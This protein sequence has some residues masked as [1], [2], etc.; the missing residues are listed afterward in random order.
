MTEITIGIDVSKKRLDV[1]V[2]PSGDEFTT[3]NDE[4]SCCELAAKLKSLNPTLIVL[5]ATGGLENLVTGVLVAEG[6]PAVVINPRQARD[7]AKATGRLAKTDR[8][9]AKVLALFGV[10]IKPEP[11]PYKDEDA[12]A[13]TAL[14][15]RRRQI[16]DMITAER[17][18]LASSHSSVKNDIAQ[19]IKWLE[20]RVKDIDDDLSGFIRR[21]ALWKA[22]ADILT[23]CKGIGPVVSTT[24]LCSLPELGTLNRRQISGL[25]GVCPY[26]RDSGTMRGKR[27][28]FGGRATVRAMLYMAALSA[29]RFNPVIKTFYDR[30]IRAGKA[31]K[32]A[33]VACMRKLLTILN[34]MLKDMKPWSPEF[35][36]AP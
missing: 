19:T 32:V 17:N 26:N 8:I 24:M 25:V 16:I 14:I 5:E 10:A 13:L 23:T 27:T 22:K 20:S 29:V 15:T 31:Y 34:A 36:Y 35:Q 1:A 4:A 33:M 21:N 2:L 6:L 3:L 28:I 30:L 11:R 7:F 18:R 9:D 12:Q